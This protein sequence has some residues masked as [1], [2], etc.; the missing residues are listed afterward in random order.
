[1]DGEVAES[2]G[3]GSELT[4]RAAREPNQVA[5]GERESAALRGQLTRAGENVDE[6]V[7]VGPGVSANDAGGR[8]PD[9]IGVEIT[10]AC[11][12]LPS[13]AGRVGVGGDE[14]AVAQKTR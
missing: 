4:M 12:K 1:M 3:P 11:L 13:R 7:D 2:V 5:R 6:D 8:Q 10:F 9:D 14:C